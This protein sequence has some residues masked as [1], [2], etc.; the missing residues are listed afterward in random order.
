MLRHA[1]FLL[2]SAALAGP[3]AATAIG[4]AVTYGPAHAEWVKLDPADR[5]AVGE[6][7][8]E[9]P[10][11]FVFDEDQNITLERD[12][13]VDVGAYGQVIPKG[14]VV[15]SH[16]V[17]FDP[18]PWAAQQGYVDFDSVIIGV[19]TSRDTL[20]ASDFLAN[21]DVEYLNPTLRGLEWRDR[22]WIDPDDP[23]R[24]RVDWIALSPGDYVR[25][26]TARSPGV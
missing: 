19:A 7:T 1:A 26:F 21:T 5:F 18:G 15:A 12:L 6:D 14:S 10:H 23:F 24:I 22:V 3:A 4:G 8:F 13:T 25:V 16:Y 20:K 9:A 11:L 17:F 2:L